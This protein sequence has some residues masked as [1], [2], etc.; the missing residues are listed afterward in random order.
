MHVRSTAIHAP[1]RGLGEHLS[2]TWILDWMTTAAQYSGRGIVA[3]T[4]QDVDA[5]LTTPAA[6]IGDDR[7]E[8]GAAIALQCSRVMTTFP[9]LRA[10]STYLCASTMSSKR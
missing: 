3:A 4:Q 7:H 10:V 2:F 8:G 5:T 6:R 1:Q 9:F